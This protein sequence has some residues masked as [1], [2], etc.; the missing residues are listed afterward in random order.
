MSLQHKFKMCIKI[1]YHIA[2]KFLHHL[3]RGPSIFEGGPDNLGRGGH[4]KNL[5]AWT[6][7]GPHPTLRGGARGGAT[8]KSHE[9]WPD[10]GG[11]APPGP[12]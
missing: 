2:S 8:E 3:E 1:Y 11:P 10:E 7:H 5:V 12:P 6:V 9:I 4:T